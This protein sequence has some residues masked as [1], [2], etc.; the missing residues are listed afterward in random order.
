VSL[1]SGYPR[2]ALLLRMWYNDPPVG[3]HGGTRSQKVLLERAMLEL[4][5]MFAVC[6]VVAKI[7][8][9]DDQ[10]GILWFG[11]TFA[12]CMTS[13]YFVPLPFVRLGIAGA[14]AFGAMIAYKVLA[15]N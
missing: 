10:S 4:A 7:A 13:L 3:C 8:S 15:K 1:P 5:L 2:P 11:V 6:A 14:A 12:L 9:A